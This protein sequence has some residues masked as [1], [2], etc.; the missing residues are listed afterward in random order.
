M[1]AFQS[2]DKRSDTSL[3]IDMQHEGAGDKIMVVIE[4]PVQVLDSIERAGSLASLLSLGRAFLVRR[5]PQCPHLDLS[6]RTADFRPPFLPSLSYQ[7]ARQGWSM[8]LLYSTMF[9][10]VRG[11][12]FSP[13]TGQA[14]PLTVSLLE[15][16]AASLAT[17]S[18]C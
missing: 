4:E 5:T 9:A 1:E 7:A 10:M 8:L 6:I 11:L 15:I 14:L 16:V 12:A 18:C 17:R 3:C 13:G 2:K